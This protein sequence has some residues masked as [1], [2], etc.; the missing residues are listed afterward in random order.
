M[1]PTLHHAHNHEAR[2][3]CRVGVGVGKAV[4][5]QEGS[6]VHA[7]EEQ[8]A[9]PATR[10]QTRMQQRRRLDTLRQPDEAPGVDENEERRGV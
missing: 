6:A 5:V 1:A 9:G 8:A 4:G 2:R 7:A 3:V 10:T